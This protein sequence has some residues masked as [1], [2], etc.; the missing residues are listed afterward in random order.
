MKIYTKTGDDGTTALIGGSR[1]SKSA[2]RIDA[3]GEIDELNSYIGLLRDLEVN[4]DKTDILK[5]IQDRL[6]TIGAHL[7]L[8][9]DRDS[10]KVP[11][12]YLSDLERLEKEIDEMQMGLPPLRSFILPGGHPNVS[13]G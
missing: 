5:E 9:P 7:A 12:L 1:V 13:F 6:F 4:A 11:D 3:Y 10:R 8:P 2:L